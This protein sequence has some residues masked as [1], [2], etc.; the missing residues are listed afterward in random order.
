MTFIIIL[1]SYKDKIVKRLKYL[2]IFQ[3]I[4]LFILLI[5]S[6]FFVIDWIIKYFHL[7]PL[8]TALKAFDIL[9]WIIPAILLNMAVERFL[10]LPLEETTGRT[11]PNAYLYFGVIWHNCLCV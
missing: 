6:E 9:W 10:W 2:W 8:A 11:V 4:F 3:V 7:V 1:V 5:S